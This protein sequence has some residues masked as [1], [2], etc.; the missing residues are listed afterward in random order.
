MTTEGYPLGYE[1]FAGNRPRCDHAARDRRSHGKPLRAD[2]PG[3]WA[4]DRGMVSTDNIEWLQERGSRYIVGTPK[5]QLRHFECQL[6]QGNWT[7]VR[8]GLEVKTC[9]GPEGSE[10]FILC[11]SE[12]RKDKERAMRERFQQRIEEGLEKI[13]VACDSRR[14]KL[15]VIER[16]I[17]RLMAARTAA[18][19]DCS[20]CRL[21]TTAVVRV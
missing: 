6:A 19:L 14:Q 3:I 18:R 7:E 5:S 2:E 1:V 15:G 12:N 8:E 10:T 16:R 20:M 4:L 17:G 9:K 13:R 11:R 21:A